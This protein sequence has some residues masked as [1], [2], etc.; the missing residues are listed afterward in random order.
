MAGLSRCRAHWG[1]RQQHCPLDLQSPGSA[2]LF[3]FILFLVVKE[4]EGNP[5]LLQWTAHPPHLCMPLHGLCG[6]QHP[7][8]VPGEPQLILPCC[9]SP[10]WGELGDREVL[11]GAALSRDPRASELL[12]REDPATES[13]SEPDS[14][15][16]VL[17]TLC[18]CGHSS[19]SLQQA[20]T[21]PDTAPLMYT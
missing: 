10:S 19:T 9:G 18:S 14:P 16:V 2:S 1:Q 5:E 8:T 11:R 6:G 15:A 13:A 4:E 21:A 7:D 17:L 20:R 3:F 12:A